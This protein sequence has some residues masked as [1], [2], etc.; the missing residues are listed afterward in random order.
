M[1]VGMAWLLAAV[2]LAGCV[3]SP[4]LPASGADSVSAQEYRLGAGDKFRLNV[5][6]EPTLSGQEYS[7][8]TNG[9]AS[10]PLIG[11]VP[12]SGL[13]TSEA[14]AAVTSRYAQGFINAPR[15]NVN[16]TQFRPF[17]ILGEVAHPGQY[18]FAN[19]MTVLNA[20]AL[21]EGFTFRADKTKVY[22]RHDTGGG[23]QVVPLAADTPV[24]P[25]DTVRIIER[26][27]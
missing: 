14:E 21:A 16:I 11:P 10:L 4:P 5:F 18:P 19:G 6:N 3:N 13:T 23:E 22:I 8:S 26:F 12:L 1:R 25:G 24:R 20:V 17:Y 15:V 7:I 27:F 2:A 9:D